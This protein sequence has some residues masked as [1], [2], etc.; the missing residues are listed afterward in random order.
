LLGLIGVWPFPL[1][2]L[3]PAVR[4]HDVVTLLSSQGG[5]PRVD[6]SVANY[7]WN[8][9]SNGGAVGLATPTEAGLR[10]L[11]GR[12]TAGAMLGSVLVTAGL[13]AAVAWWPRDWRGWL[14]V[15]WLALPQLVLARHTLD[16]LLHYLYPELPVLALA[17]GVLVAAVEARAARVPALGLAVAAALLVYVASSLATLFVSLGYIEHADTHLGY[18][19]PLR[20]SFQAGQTAR[21]LAPPGTPVVIGAHH[22]NGEILRFTLG[23][24]RSSATFDDCLALPYVPGA[25]YL[26]LSEQTPGA[27]AL[28]KA[29]AQLLVRL[30][31]PGDAY[32]IYTAPPSPFEAADLT[33]N[34]RSNSQE[35]RER[36][37]WDRATTTS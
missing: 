14:I 30:E 21:A 16:V 18:G 24:D 15:A 8:L 11:F 26:L 10:A 2:E 3:N 28:E 27:D 37:D 9:A 34:P 19:I 5:A 25:L 29:G 13:V 6:L 7:L 1:Y 33:T 22:Y 12:W 17:V 35:C 36:R 20:D 23:Y 4:L 32:R 31:R